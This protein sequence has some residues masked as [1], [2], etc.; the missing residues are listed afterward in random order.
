MGNNLTN[1]VQGV[2][3]IQG[4][5]GVQGYQGYRG[6]QGI[7]GKIGQ[8]GYKGMQGVRGCQGLPGDDGTNGVQGVQGRPGL[9]GIRGCQGISGLR[10]TQGVQGLQGSKGLRGPRGYIGY[11]GD[12]GEVGIQGLQGEGGATVWYDGIRLNGYNTNLFVYNTFSDKFISVNQSFPDILQI[13]NGAE[14]KILVDET[15][16]EKLIE[17]NSIKIDEVVDG[18]FITTNYPAYYKDNKEISELLISTS[19]Q[20]CIVSFTYRN[21]G[22]YYSAGI[23]GGGGG[24]DAIFTQSFD[25]VSMNLGEMTDGTHVDVGEK[26]EDVVRKMLQKSVDVKATRPTQTITCSRTLPSNIEVGSSLSFTLTSVLKDGYF[27]SDD[28]TAYPNDKFDQVNAPNAHNG[29]LDAGCTA[30]DISYYMNGTETASGSITISSFTENTYTFGASI[31]YSASSVV[32]KKSTGADSEVNIP[33][34]TV[35]PETKYT[36]NGKYK[37]FIGTTEAI[38]DSGDKP[39]RNVFTTKAS[40][41]TLTSAWINK[42]GSTQVA[43]SIISTNE[44]PSIVLVIPDF[45]LIESICNSFGSEIEDPYDKLRFQNTIQYTTGSVTTTYN[46]YVMHNISAIEYKYI[47][48]KK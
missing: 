4:C 17:T 25:V 20:N 40:L 1:G 28:K 36:I 21:G 47:K 46:V 3:G 38:Y 43:E 10:G 24:G 13:R 19:S 48:I 11:R 41:S 6:L 31:E 9:Q 15:A 12:N 42:T 27:E 26:I 35:G 33:S 8:P 2:Q 14:I 44:K 32:A 34:G 5:M 16:Y 7:Q 23:I 22:W 18:V 30:V 39:Y 45:M 29:K 37:A